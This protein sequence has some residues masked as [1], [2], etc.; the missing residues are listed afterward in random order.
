MVYIWG[1]PEI[2][3]FC[4]LTAFFLKAFSIMKIYM[5]A[6]VLIGFIG[7]GNNQA[8]AEYG[9]QVKSDHDVDNGKLSDRSQPTKKSN[10]LPVHSFEQ[11]CHQVEG[12]KFYSSLKYCACP[13]PDKYFVINN[14]KGSC[15]QNFSLDP[16]ED[17][18]KSPAPEIKKN[19]SDSFL[20]KIG[21]FCSKKQD[22]RVAKTETN[23]DL[24]SQSFFGIDA[25]IGVYAKSTIP[26]INPV[27]ARGNSHYFKNLVYSV[28]LD[29]E[30]EK[31]DFYLR[32]L[33]DYSLPRSDDYYQE[34]Y[35]FNDKENYRSS[36]SGGQL[37]VVESENQDLKIQILIDAYNELTRDNI[38]VKSYGH[39][40]VFCY[41]DYSW[42][43]YNQPNTE[44]HIFGY[45]SY[46]SSVRTTISWRSAV[47]GDI[48]S[49]MQL[50]PSNKIASVVSLDEEKQDG[51]IFN[52][53]S[54][55]EYPF[56]KAVLRTRSLL[57]DVDQ[58]RKTA[59]NSTSAYSSD[60]PH[61]LVCD[62]GSIENSNDQQ[63]SIHFVKGFDSSSALGWLEEGH[64]S[65]SIEYDGVSSTL[66]NALMVPESHLFSVASAVTKTYGELSNDN[67][68]VGIIPVGYQNCT[69]NFDL[70]ERNL[71]LT[72]AK[73]I[74]VSVSEMIHINQCYE[75][76]IAKKIQNSKSD[77]LWVMAAGNTPNERNPEGRYCPQQAVGGSNV[78]IVSQ[79]GL[80]HGDAY[81][82]IYSDHDVGG[83]GSTFAAATVSALAARIAHLYPNLKVWQI[84]MAILASGNLDFSLK[85]LVKTS[86]K[87]N[88]ERAIEAADYISKM[89]PSSVDWT[90]TQLLNSMYSQ[91]E[92]DQRYFL[93]NNRNVFPVFEIN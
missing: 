67:Q 49:I 25:N 40:G 44:I 22:D 79:W 28:F 21:F 55:F 81:S 11:L 35:V 87:I 8:D 20:C 71:K 12:T 45:R 56:K 38:D 26:E 46:G 15:I 32:G 6:F 59:E 91:I 57:I 52:N 58:S 93:Y 14:S 4:C 34:K 76:K 51:K 75:S 43:V 84:R 69:Y 29:S 7:C 72:N 63:D 82:D 9:S 92:S 24:V 61:V 27:L 41:V 33:F 65:Y 66:G 13:S 31:I 83:K 78:I 42:P 47:S 60:R 90:L 74:N 70:L 50:T 18:A 37:S 16:T 54:I 62:V 80:S 73:V 53:Y 36:F 77:Y 88:R 2:P 39:C 3:F 89:A 10:I 48:Y 68:G 64:R 86:S 5:L 19:E 17:I 1:A 23:T 30:M 85:N